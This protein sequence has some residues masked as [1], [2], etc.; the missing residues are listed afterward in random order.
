MNGLFVSQIMSLEASQLDVDK[1]EETREQLECSQIVSEEVFHRL[2]EESM[3]EVN[4]LVQIEKND[5]LLDEEKE[6]QEKEDP[7]QED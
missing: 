4:E 2:I 3:K 7:D 5:P 1:A 6:D